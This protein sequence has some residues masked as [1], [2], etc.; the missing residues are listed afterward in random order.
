MNDPEFRT[1]YGKISIGDHVFLG[2]RATVLKGVILGRGA[3][4]CACALVAK[5]V[6]DYEIVA[7]VPAKKIAE[8]AKNLTYKPEWGPLFH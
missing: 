3:V 5:P 8:R 1:R 4:V 6:G 7:G 2:L